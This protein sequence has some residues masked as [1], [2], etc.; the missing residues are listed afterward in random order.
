MISFLHL[1][2]LLGD[3][4][5]FKKICSFFNIPVIEN[6]LESKF[7][8]YIFN[9]NLVRSYFLYACIVLISSLFVTYFTITYIKAKQTHSFYSSIIFL[10]MI[11]FV[12][13]FLFIVRYYKKNPLKQTKNKFIG[14][15]LIQNTAFLLLSIYISLLENNILLFFSFI[16]LIATLIFLSPLVIFILYPSIMIL[17]ILIAVFLF[18]LNFANYYPALLA[19]FVS[20][21]ISFV[22]YVNKLTE[23]NLFNGFK[24]KNMVLR[25]SNKELSEFSYSDALTGVNNRRRIEDIL[26]D[27]WKYCKQNNK[28]L[29]VI[30]IDIDNFKKYND[31]YGH[32][33]GDECLIKIANAI[34]DLCEIFYPTHYCSMGRYGGEEFIIL[35]PKADKESVINFGKL[36]CKKIES[37]NIPHEQNDEYPYV[38]ISCGA[39]TMIPDDEKRILY[40][41]EAADRALYSVKRSGKNNI[42]HSSDI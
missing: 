22:I 25:E 10:I 27:N 15:I 5:M 28:Y 30:F 8:S 38:T 3:M 40:I 19:I 6:E 37:L 18:N 33:A 35:L 23:F 14:F 39:T 24:E 12:F 34:N 1:F 4:S 31:S 7:Y 41:L 13:I 26:K 11:L 29:S 32:V 16:V 9:A 42:Y 21:I 17:Y 2:D 36:V 20:G